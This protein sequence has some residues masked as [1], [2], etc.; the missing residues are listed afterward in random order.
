[1]NTHALLIYFAV[2]AILSVAGWF[3]SGWLLFKEQKRAKE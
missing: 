2:L 3:I 1:M